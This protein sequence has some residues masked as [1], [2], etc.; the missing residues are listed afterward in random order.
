MSD[1]VKKILTTLDKLTESVLTPTGVTKGLNAQQRSVPQLPAEFRPRSIKVLGAATDPQHPA[2]KF[3]VGGESVDQERDVLDKDIEATPNEY[4]IY[5]RRKLDNTDRWSPATKHT[6]ADQARQVADRIVRSNPDYEYIIREKNGDVGEW[7]AEYNPY[8]PNASPV[9]RGQIHLAL[10]DKYKANNIP[11]L[12]EFDDG[13]AFRIMKIS[14]KRWFLDLFDSYQRKGKED[15]FFT[16]LGTG[17]GFQKLLQRYMLDRA[18]EMHKKLLTPKKPKTVAAQRRHTDYM[19]EETNQDIRTR[20]ML[21]LVRQQFPAATSDTE[22]LLLSI[23]DTRQKAKT[24]I[25]N[26]EKEI[27]DAESGIRGELERTLGDIKTQR[28]NLTRRVS[29]I[30]ANDENQEQIINRIVRIDQDQQRA[31]D[32]L[33]RTMQQSPSSAAKQ[34]NQELDALKDIPKSVAPAARPEAPAVQT[35]RSKRK[36]KTTKTKDTAVD[37]EPVDNVFQLRQPELPFPGDDDE[38]IAQVAARPRKAA[39]SVQSA[40]PKLRRIHYFRVDDTTAAKQ[41]GLVQDRGGNWTLLQYDKSGAPFDRKFTQVVRLFGRPVRS[42]Y[43]RESKIVKRPEITVRNPVAKHAPK[44]G[45]GAHPNKK[46]ADKHGD[47]KHKKQELAEAAVR[48]KYQNLYRQL[49]QLQQSSRI[50]TGHG[51]GLAKQLIQQI[52]QIVD[53]KLPGMERPTQDEWLKEMSMFAEG[54]GSDMIAT[55]KLTMD[56]GTTVKI[57]TSFDEIDRDSAERTLKLQHPKLAGRS[58]EKIQLLDYRVDDNRWGR[59]PLKSFPDIRPTEPFGRDVDNP[60]TRGLKEGTIA[61]TMAEIEEDMISKVKKDLTQYL[62]KLEKRTKLDRDLQDKAVTAVERGRTEE[63]AVDEDPTAM[64]T[65]VTPPPAPTVNPTL[66]EEAT[67]KTVTLE[68]GFMLEIYGDESR[69]FGIRR[70]GRELGHRFPKLDHA[71]LAIELYKA[72]RPQDLSQ[73]YVQER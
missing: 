29:A 32:D 39:E 50:N 41:A 45:A 4:K 69:G 58:I 33:E 9:A 66:P 52:Q 28:S 47:V 7:Q 68:D 44:S 70:Q 25:D 37:S 40:R 19:K 15:Q 16:L 64:D 51:R 21:D 1:D 13:T 18:K 53:N 31:L 14:D 3:F 34:A 65:M 26:L 24:D 72:N 6:S 23:N 5:I 2:R 11:V 35:T 56:D 59:A 71:E 55:W 46:L 63:I 38:E 73:D 43:V 60:M 30:Q 22:A 49:N 67:V 61:E 8:P 27:D 20:R 62:D 42:E 48:Q 12:V 36:T 54:M 17:P 57:T 10:L